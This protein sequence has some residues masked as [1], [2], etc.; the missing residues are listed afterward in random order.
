VRLGLVPLLLALVLRA[1]V[2]QAAGPAVQPR[3]APGRTYLILPFENVAEDPS[4]D[5]LSTGLA[6]S[7]GENLVGWGVP[8]GVRLVDEDERSVILE[9]SGIPSGAPLTLASALE[10]GRR[11]R[12]HTGAARPDRLVLGRFNLEEGSLTLSARSID[13]EEEKA[14]PWVAR[15]GPLQNLLGVQLA[16]AA[17]LARGEGL[18]AGL[19]RDAPP[20]P[21]A[22]G[23]PLLAFE[24][25]CK[26]MA[27]PDLKKRLQLLRKAVQQ[28]PAYGK[29]AY[30]AAQLLAKEERWDEVSTMLEKAGSAASPYP[31]TSA[32][33]LL[34]AAVALHRRD[35]EAA[36][37]AARRA[38]DYAD[39]ARGHL[40]LGRAL[41]ASG[42]QEQ[43]RAEID[44]ARTLDPSEPE[45]D[46]LQRSLDEGQRPPRRSP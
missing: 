12:A 43:A 34:A 28:F 11:M 2:A 29:A 25:Y 33:H 18:E 17:D 3:A 7:L 40:L 46:D 39:T 1:P 37:R 22:E 45:I 44:I 27:E 5:W 36:A 21:A 19:P 26:A 16:L 31:Y 30:Q 42:N 9:G 38:L 23:L 14:R 15:H 13:L 24:T 8:S 32:Y 20:G 35:P 41:L 10:L 6:L 4:L